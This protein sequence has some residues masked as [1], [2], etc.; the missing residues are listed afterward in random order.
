[1]G[2]LYQQYYTK[3]NEIVSYMID[4]LNLESNSLVLEPCAGD[5]VFID[6]LLGKDI[7]INIEAFELDPNEATKLKNRY[8][9]NSNIIIRNEDTLLYN[10]FINGTYFNKYDYIIANPPYGAWQ[11]YE[12]RDLLKNIYPDL[13]IKETYSTFLYLCIKLLKDGGRLVFIIPDTYLNLHMHTHLRKHILLNTCVEE[14]ALFPSKFFPGV[15]FGYSK[16]SII[17][18]IKNNKNLS[19]SISVLDNFREVRQLNSQQNIRKTIIRQNDILRNEHYAFII[20]DNKRFNILL[21]NS[22]LQ[23]SDIANCVTGIYTGNDKIFIKVLN[24]TIKNSK[25]YE[26]ITETEKSNTLFDNELIGFDTAPFYIPIVKGGN[27]RYLKNNIWFINWSKEA[28]TIYKSNKKSRFQNSQFYFKQGIA[29]PMV[30]SN[31]VSASILNNR[32]FDQ[33]IVGVFPKDEKY[34]YYLLAFF[35]SNV[36]LKLLRIIN[37]SANNSANYIKKLPV[38]LPEQN[39]LDHINHL[40]TTVIAMKALETDSDFVESELNNIFDRIYNENEIKPILKNKQQELF[41]V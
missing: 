10:D 35:N 9:N 25:N 16:L 30:G 41:A 19:N 21:K 2:N 20:S 4:K 6:A 22:L 3:S 13:Y 29:V 40:V 32:L 11:D 34:I 39:I 5:G 31:C 23:M 17:T 15:N 28:V 38:I 7:N 36:C 26:I 12:K 1:M 33:S 8:S 27:T 24:H 14:I 37:P 18:L